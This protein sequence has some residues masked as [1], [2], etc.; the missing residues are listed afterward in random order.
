[1]L[2]TLTLTAFLLAAPP[3]RAGDCQPDQLSHDL[4]EAAPV[5]RARLFLQLA[6][7]DEEAARAIAPEAVPTFLADEDGYAAAVRALELGVTEPVTAWIAGLQSD[8]R[9]HAIEAVGKACDQ[10]EAVQG[11]IKNRA[12]SMGEDF[13]TERW[14]RTIADCHVPLLQDILWRKLANGPDP[15]NRTLFSGVLE[16]YARSAG[17]AAIP[18]L[19]ELATK[20]DDA[21]AQTYIV[22]SFADAARVGSVEGPDPKA[23]QAAI[24]AIQRIAPKL[25]TKAVEQ[26][27]LTLLAL[28][29]ERASDELVAV[30]YKDRLR[31]DGSL[32]WGVVAVENATCR[33]GK[34]K[35]RV[36]VA[37][38][39]DPGQTWPDQVQE[40]VEFS[41]KN[42]WE[43]DLA[44]ACKGTEEVQ[45]LVPAEPFA[46]K[47]AWKAWVD[48]TLRSVTQEG[49]KQSRV[50][51]DPL[52]L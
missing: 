22:M 52:A 30:R 47:A 32:M 12:R 26:A 33:N 40:K 23:V 18:K 28:G 11:Y 36:H 3:A 43:L 7:C 48:E 51:H 19:E 15:R 10:S 20:V 25:Q 1:M 37:A 8:E 9:A 6:G 39:S 31:E 35:Q 2:S 50:D 41:V 21:E 24:Q 34:K 16:A 46:D 4:M 49:V 13:W 29:D 27:R 38:V 17:G 14:Y 42:S 44:R 5:Q 45:V